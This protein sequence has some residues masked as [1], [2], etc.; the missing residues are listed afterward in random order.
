MNLKYIKRFSL[1]VLVSA[2]LTACSSSPAIVV[3][4]VSN[5][6]YQ[7]LGTTAGSACGSILLGPTSLN[8]IPI[9]LSSRVENAYQDALQNKP[10]A[11]GIINITM[12]EDWVWWLLGSSKCVKITGEAIR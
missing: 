3:P 12:K 10:G 2:A 4:V 1:I 7:S 8:F 5:P 11:T 6:N 9:G